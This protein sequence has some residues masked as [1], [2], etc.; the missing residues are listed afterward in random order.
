MKK[1]FIGAL[2]A[3][4][5]IQITPLHAD[6]E[7]KAKVSSNDSTAGFL[8]GKLVAGTGISLTENNDGGNETLT[9]ANSLGSADGA[10]EFLYIE[11]A[12]SNNFE[13][14]LGSTDPTADRT[15]LFP[16]ASLAA[17]DVLVG[18]AANT[19]SYVNLATTNILVGDGSGAPSAVSLSG[20]VTMTNTGVVSI[21]VNSVALGTDSTGNYVATVADA[22]NSTITV[23][24]SGSE[25]AAV[26]LDAIDVNCSNCID[27]SDIAMGSD[28]S[29]DIMYYNGTDYVR[30]AKGSDGQFLSLS[31]GTPTWDTPAGSGDVTAV[32]SC[33]SGDCFVDGVN[34]TLVF[35]GSTVDTSE[36]T[37]GAVDPTGDRTINLPNASGTIL[38]GNT[39]TDT[40]ICTYDGTNRYI[41]CDTTSGGSG[42][43]TAVGPAY[44]SGDAFV[45]GVVST[46]TTMLVWE[47][48]TDN[49]NELSI[50]SST[51][52]P[53][54]DIDIT[55]PS[56]TGTL[57]TIAG[58]ATLT[59][60]TLAAADNVIEA[61]TGDSATSFFSAGT[62]E[63]ARLPSSMADKV[64]TGSL[65]IPQGASPTVDATGEIGL[66]T[67]ATQVVY[68]DGSAVKALD[69][70]RTAC[71][72]IADVVAADDNFTI[73]TANQAVTITS[74]GCYCEGTC[75]TKPTF[76]LEDNSG[77]AMT[78]TGTNPTCAV[79]TANATYAAVTAGNSLVAGESL[80]FDVTN[81]TSP[82]TDDDI[83]CWT[84]TVDRA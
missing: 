58:T 34:N 62:L 84:Y 12:T 8:N 25:T 63:D 4:F 11:G 67:T 16:D 60:K 42:D 68:Y 14:I 17:S 48:T 46:G 75:T 38:V 45:G 81:T 80:R 66:D 31:S 74:V 47:G 1:W 30:L 20:D 61:D 76:T 43:I 44:A 33:A 2:V 13:T 29:G 10:S 3:L 21:A 57:D 69:P 54:S 5:L 73:W 78:I 23:S 65:A 35:E 22:G 36:T 55:L 6:I 82:T 49:T 27:G 51:A 77:N 18:S 24:G 59:N 37:V 72:R 32:G 79:T 83:L 41:N 53:A 50:I 39:L 15:I 70:V 56:A 19:L 71:A 40:R 26:T 9:I 52:D 64:I 7:R 28:A